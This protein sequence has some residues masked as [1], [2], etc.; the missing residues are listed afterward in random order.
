[1]TA[2]IKRR[3]GA[4]WSGGV[5][6]F[7]PALATVSGTVQDHGDGRYSQTIVAGRRAGQGSVGVRTGLFRVPARAE[8][9]LEPGPADPAHSVFDVLVG[10]LK[11][12]TNQRGRFLV[13]LMPADSLGNAIRGARVEIDGSGGP[14]LRWDG[15]VRESRPGVYDRFFWGPGEAGTLTFTARVNGSALAASTSLDVFDPESPEGQRIACVP[16]PAPPDSAVGGWWWI[17][18]LILLL[19]LLLFWFWWRS[20]LRPAVP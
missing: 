5:V 14:S 11:L 19:L 8:L 18:L 17:L 13:Q 6:S 10:P 2:R 12:C 1:V 15:P 7:V 9:R 4:P 3:D 16:I 20:R